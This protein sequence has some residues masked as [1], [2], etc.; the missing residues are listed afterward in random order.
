MS[1][2]SGESSSSSSTAAVMAFLRDSRTSYTRAALQSHGVS[3]SRA[4]P[5]DE[6]RKDPRVAA[7]AYQTSPMSKQ[8]MEPHYFTSRA[9]SIDSDC[10]R[11]PTTS[12]VGNKGDK[13]FPT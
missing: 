1:F 4:W 5:D 10:C 6:P 3:K 8:P 11:P 7:P 13:S 12:V 9:T 2:P